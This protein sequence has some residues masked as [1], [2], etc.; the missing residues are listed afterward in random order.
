MIYTY[1]QI[2]SKLSHLAK[3]ERATPKNVQYILMHLGPVQRSINHYR[4]FA[5]HKPTSRPAREVY[6]RMEG[7]EGR[8]DLILK[9][10]ENFL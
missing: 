2:D 6:R 10:F 9:K 7:F 1:E 8:I 4:A 5:D 3:I